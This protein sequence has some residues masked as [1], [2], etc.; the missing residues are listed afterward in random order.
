MSGIVETIYFGGQNLACGPDT[1]AERAAFAESVE[2]IADTSA[3]TDRPVPWDGCPDVI[4]KLS[5]ALTWPTSKSADHRTF[6]RLRANA[7]P[8]D[9]CLWKYAAAIFS[10]NGTLTEFILPW[11]L[12][13]K[14]LDVGSWP[15]PEAYIET[16]YAT[17]VLVDGVALVETTDYVI[18]TPDDLGRTPITFTVAPADEIGNIEVY[19]VPLLLMRRIGDEAGYNREAGMTRTLTVE[20]VA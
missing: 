10:G 8:F 11:R 9:V 17:E 20:E 18:G 16:E 6:A 14:S 12:A 1:I 13:L 3:V 15:A 7:A 19:A 4:A 2:R 5:F